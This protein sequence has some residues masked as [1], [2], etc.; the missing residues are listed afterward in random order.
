M[1][2]TSDGFTQEI[3]DPWGNSRRGFVA[4]TKIN[5]KDFGVN[6]NKT[7]DGGGV[8]VGDEVDINVELELVAEKKGAKG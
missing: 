5:R 8:V 6:W 4:N 3:K 1:T 2:L 7:M